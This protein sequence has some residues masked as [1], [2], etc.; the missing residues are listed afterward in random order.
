MYA[1]RDMTM[2][3]NGHFRLLISTTFSSSGR[4]RFYKQSSSV[5]GILARLMWMTFSPDDVIFGSLLETVWVST[6][7]AAASIIY[8]DG[9]HSDPKNFKN[10]LS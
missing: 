2:K 4:E 3:L 10:L 6:I 1:V 7:A 8:D 5:S 9:H